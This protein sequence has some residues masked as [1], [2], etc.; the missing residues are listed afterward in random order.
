MYDVTRQNYF[1]R[2]NNLSY[3]KDE[4]NNARHVISDIEYLKRSYFLLQILL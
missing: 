1:A 4:E 2:A 3:V